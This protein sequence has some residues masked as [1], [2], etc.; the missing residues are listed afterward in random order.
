M[1]NVL[2]LIRAFL[3]EMGGELAPEAVPEE[4]LYDL[5]PSEPRAVAGQFFQVPSKASRRTALQ[6]FQTGRSRTFLI[7]KIVTEGDARPVHYASVASAILRRADGSLA[8]FT[9]PLTAHLILLDLDGLEDTEVIDRYREG[10]EI[11]DTRPEQAGYKARRL[12]AMRAASRVQREM[13]EEGLIALHEG[14]EPGVLVVVDASLSG[15]E[16]AEDM[17]GVIGLVPA[18]A[19][20]LGG[21]SVVLGLPFGARSALDT[22]NSPPAFYI[23]MRDSSGM[24]PD[25]GLVRVELGLNPDSGRADEAWASDV[26]SLLMAERLPI[27][28]GAENWDKSIYA[29]LSAAKYIDTLIPSPGVVTTYFGRS[30]A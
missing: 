26:A 19:D 30:T 2:S 15:I 3:A 18:V 8:P 22:A 13:M 27:D 23:R 10:I 9:R 6:L 28:L 24:N 25:F 17:P 21:E 5:P 11:I 20:V 7:G 29:L 12:A 14:R 1:Q 16:G 4:D